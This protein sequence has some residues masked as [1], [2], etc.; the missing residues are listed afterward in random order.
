MAVVSV[1]ETQPSVSGSLRLANEPNALIGFT[2][3]VKPLLESNQQLTRSKRVVLPIE[4]N[5]YKY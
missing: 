3:V 2:T 5:G 1:L 4:L